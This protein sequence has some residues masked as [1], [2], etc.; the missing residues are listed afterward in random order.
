MGGFTQQQVADRA[1]IKKRMIEAYEQGEK[2]P[3]L[4]RLCVLAYALGSTPDALLRNDDPFGVG[5]ILNEP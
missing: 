2:I 3:S 1:K 5:G 4:G